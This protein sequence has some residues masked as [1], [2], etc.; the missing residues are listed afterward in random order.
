MSKIN[1][2]AGILIEKYILSTSEKAQPLLFQLRKIISNHSEIVEDWKWNAP[3]FACEGMVC[4]I[5][6]FKKHVGINF[7]KGSLI[8]DIHGY[9]EGDNDPQKG[10]RIIRYSFEDNIDEEK[11]NHYI[12]QAIQLNQNNVNIPVKKKT[13]E[14]PQFMVDILSSHPKA[15][16]VFDAFPPSHKKEYI[17]W[18]TEAKREAT[19]EKRI[20]TMLE[21]L[22]EGK[23]KNWK[24]KNC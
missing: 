20:A 5:A 15:K 10:N 18:I 8:E 1:P 11:L 14:T 4:W 23:S 7:F 9:F 2:E 24:Y 6:G 16:E 19:K 22:E 12:K 3:N 13:V 21:W 17:E